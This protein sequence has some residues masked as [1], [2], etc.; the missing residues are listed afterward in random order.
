MV[1]V[2]VFQFITVFLN[3]VSLMIKTIHIFKDIQHYTLNFS[4]TYTYYLQN[5]NQITKYLIH[6]ILFS[7]LNTYEHTL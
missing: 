5:I 1:L 2:F 4:V 3:H 6:L 7:I